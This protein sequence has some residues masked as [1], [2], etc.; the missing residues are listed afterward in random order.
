MSVGEGGSYPFWA[1]ATED[2]QMVSFSPFHVLLY[3]IVVIMV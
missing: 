1:R 3:I 2:S